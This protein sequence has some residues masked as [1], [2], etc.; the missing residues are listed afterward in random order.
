MNGRFPI[1]RAPGSSRLYEERE[2]EQWRSFIGEYPVVTFN[3]AGDRLHSYTAD[4]V[5]ALIGIQY[6]GLIQTSPPPSSWRARPKRYALGFRANTRMLPV[7][8]RGIPEVPERVPVTA[9]P[10]TP[11][12]LGFKAR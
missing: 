12:K 11:R 3:M 4:R 7:I 6:P 9:E 5:L 8:S 2:I 1:D 10:R